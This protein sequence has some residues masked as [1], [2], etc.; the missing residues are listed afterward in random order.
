MQALE[1]DAQNQANMIVEIDE[2]EISD[3]EVD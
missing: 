3:E 2:D 1:L